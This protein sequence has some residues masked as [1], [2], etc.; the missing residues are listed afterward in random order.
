MPLF[1][2]WTD[3][4]LAVQLGTSLAELQFAHRQVFPAAAE[5]PGEGEPGRQ[6]A[7]RDWQRIEK[8]GRASIKKNYVNK[9]RR[10]GEKAAL[11]VLLE[12]WI[13]VFQ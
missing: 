7:V 10:G 12:F 13:R 4:L 3:V 6:E 5:F 8:G 1:S 2:L 11:A 9:Q